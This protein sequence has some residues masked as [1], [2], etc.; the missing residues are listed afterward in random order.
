M[1]QLRV[2]MTKSEVTS[3]LGSPNSTASPGGGV[4]ILRYNLSTTPEDAQRGITDPY[5]VRLVN[6]RVESFGKMGDFGTPQDQ[7]INV[8][9]YDKP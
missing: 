6:G 8:R 9:I 1:N 2:G 3:I 4:E 7:T 5:F